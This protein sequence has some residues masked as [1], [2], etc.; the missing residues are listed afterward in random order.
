MWTRLIAFNK[1][2]NTQA[3]E[4]RSFRQ[5]SRDSNTDARPASEPSR[6]VH[7]T[8]N[9]RL[10][11][12]TIYIQFLFKL[13]ETVIHR[14]E[15]IKIRYILLYKVNTL[16]THAIGITWSQ[17]NKIDYVD[18]IIPTSNSSDNFISPKTIYIID[19]AWDPNSKSPKH[20]IIRDISHSQ[21]GMQNSNTHTSWILK[22]SWN[23]AY[24]WNRW[25]IPSTCSCC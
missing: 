2:S 8:F 7:P 17:V 5:N 24:R 25:W 6:P 14:L 23:T 18:H 20:L 22:D 4:P 13:H 12:H 21:L 1:S 16:F 19:N 9:K 11:Y 10:I 15:T 3:S